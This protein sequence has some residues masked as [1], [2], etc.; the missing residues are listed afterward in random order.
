MDIHA[1]KLELIQWIAGINDPKLISQFVE[2]KQSNLSEEDKLIVES[3]EKG[4]QNIKN[5]KVKN[6]Q[7][8]KKKY[9][10]WL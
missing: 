8:V 6:H 2:F 3:L 9:D 7:E 10:K 1:K 5:G 4:I